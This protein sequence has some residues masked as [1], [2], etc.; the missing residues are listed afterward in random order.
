VYYSD[1]DLFE[2]VYGKSDRAEYNHFKNVFEIIKRSDN[3]VI[4]DFKCGET[5]KL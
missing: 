2:N 3:V 1:Y 4:S 5:N